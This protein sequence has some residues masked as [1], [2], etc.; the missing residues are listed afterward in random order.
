[1]AGALRL[2]I[3]SV[4][5]IWPT[6]ASFCSSPPTLDRTLI[7]SISGLSRTA[8]IAHARGAGFEAANGTAY[9]QLPRLAPTISRRPSSAK[10]LLAWVSSPRSPATAVPIIRPRIDL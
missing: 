6:L 3:A 8:L 9:A 5:S 2:H 10:H 4:G 7:A 1:M